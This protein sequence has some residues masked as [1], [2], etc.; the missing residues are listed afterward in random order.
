MF[1]VSQTI[2]LTFFSKVLIMISQKILLVDDEITLTELISEG[3]KMEGEFDVMQACNGKEALE[4]YKQYL[5]DLVVMDIEMPVMDGY[6]SSS[7]IKSFDPNAKILVLT[8]NPTDVRVRKTVLEGIAL[9]VLE[10][11]VRL[12]DLNN[13]ILRNLPACA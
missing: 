13:T 1:T 2:P 11:P 6:E 8:G 7:R 3:L 5:P 4:K 12:R 10:K 9:T